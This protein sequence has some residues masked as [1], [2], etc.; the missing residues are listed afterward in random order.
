MSINPTILD[1]NDFLTKPELIDMNLFDAFSMKRQYNHYIPD[2]FIQKYPFKF[3]INIQKIIDLIKTQK[4]HPLSIEAILSN[5]TEEDLYCT[6]LNSINI[7]KL[8]GT[9]NEINTFIQ[10]YY[11]YIKWNNNS[12]YLD[13]QQKIKFKD[14]IDWKSLCYTRDLTKQILV[15]CSEYLDW[16]RINLCRTFIDIRK[17]VLVTF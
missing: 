16:E 3:K 13:E 2:E 12:V 8:N 11:K 6:I 7:G 10:K 1:P 4:I 5:F 14:Y 17:N 9:K 15:E